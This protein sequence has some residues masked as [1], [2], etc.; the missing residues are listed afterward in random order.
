MDEST[1]KQGVLIEEVLRLLNQRWVSAN[2]LET[3][4]GKMGVETND[5]GI[6]IFVL[7]QVLETYQKNPGA[8]F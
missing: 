4:P 6:K 5:L 7:N 2:D 1:I 8:I 3:I